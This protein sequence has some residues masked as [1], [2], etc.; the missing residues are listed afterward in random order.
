MILTRSPQLPNRAQVF[1]EELEYLR[2]PGT[3]RS[4]AGHGWGLGFGR[5][6]RAGLVDAQ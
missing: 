3:D 1:Q 4:N 2:G 6:A 5:G